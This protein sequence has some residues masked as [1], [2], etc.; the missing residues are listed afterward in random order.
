MGRRFVIRRDRVRPALAAGIAASIAMTLFA[1]LPG[2]AETT[3]E[4]RDA[5]T[6]ADYRGN[7]GTHNWSTWWIELGELTDPSAGSISVETVDCVSNAC[8]S[9]GR[10]AGGD[11]SVQ[12]TF[13]S[14]GADSV[15]LSFDYQRHR[16]DPGGGT[17]RLLTSRN[18]YSNWVVVDSWQLTES[19]AA[20]QFVSYD[21][22]AVASPFSTIRFELTGNA[23]ESHM[24]ID[25]VE[26]LVTYDTTAPPAFNQDLGDRDDEVGDTVSIDASASDPD[27]AALTYTASGLPAGVAIDPDSGLISGTITSAVGSPLDVEIVVTDPDDNGDT[28][29]FVWTVTAPPTTTTTTMPPTTTTVPPTT[30]TVPPTT[31]TVPPTTTTVPPTTT[32]VPPT[33][34]TTVPPQPPQPPCPQPQ[35]P[36]PQPQPRCPQPR[37]R[38]CDRK[39]VHQRP[40]RPPRPDDDDTRDD[41]R[42]DHD[43]PASGDRP[44]AAHHDHHGPART[45]HA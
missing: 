22:T 17:V 13:F 8:L 38:R 10:S 41:D 11:A 14:S 34:T 43:H 42:P 37:Q 3:L 44:G 15:T 7:D 26:V 16:L 23:N 28:D 19:D 39:P 31:T 9:L 24:N 20:R 1:P 5:F 29:S 45:D 2:V 25:D 18:G 40:R 21:I 6:N 33:T 36:C 27:S 35:P 32:T 4:F 12:R 30:T